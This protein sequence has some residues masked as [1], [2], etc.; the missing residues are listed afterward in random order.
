MTCCNTPNAKDA[1]SGVFGARF[2]LAK[3][4]LWALVLELQEWSGIRGMREKRMEND[5]KRTHWTT[6]L[7]RCLEL[8]WAEMILAVFS[9]HFALAFPRAMV[10][11]ILAILGVVLLAKAIA[12]I[13]KKRR[14]KHS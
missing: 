3:W 14:S 11:I 9:F 10:R 5:G 1:G 8:P 6:W 12:E 13:I 7:R 2:F 4:P